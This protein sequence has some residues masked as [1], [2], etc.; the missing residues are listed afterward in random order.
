MIKARGVR[1]PSGLVSP[2]PPDDDADG[3]LEHSEMG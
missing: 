2:L 3:A 1:R